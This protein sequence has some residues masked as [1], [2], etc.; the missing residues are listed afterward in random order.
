MHIVDSTKMSSRTGMGCGPPAGRAPLLSLELTSGCR[1]RALIVAFVVISSSWLVPLHLF[2]ADRQIT[3]RFLD[4]KSAKPIRKMWVGVTQYKGDPPKGPIPAEY[5]VSYLNSKT[6]QNGEIVV[7]L[8]DP[9]PTF[10]SVIADLWYNGSLISVG[11]VLKSGVVL[12]YSGK[13]APHGRWVGDKGH[14]S[15]ESG[16][17]LNHR[18]KKSAATS[19]PVPEPG[20]IVFV[21]KRL[22]L[23]DNLRQEIP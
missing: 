17:L 14:R 3:V 6:D 9:L 11:E 12:D 22:T 16:S 20:V 21:E 23:W 13:G 1:A 8:H 18:D 19:K 2:A 5:R 4:P 10:V 7:A 15:M